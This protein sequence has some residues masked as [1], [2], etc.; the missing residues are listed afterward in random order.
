[1]SL[2]SILKNISYSFGGNLLSFLV[3]VIMVLFVPKFLPILDYS[4]WQL[5]LF[6]FS[7]V[8]FFHLGW[9]DGI[10]L[11]YAG[12]KYKELDR[13]LFAGQLYAILLLQIMIA[14]GMWLFA[15]YGVDDPVKSYVL[16]CTAVL[17]PFVNFNNACNQIMQFTNRI[18]EYAQLLVTGRLLLL[19]FVSFFLFLGWQTY[20]FMYYAQTFSVVG[21][22]IFGAYL[23]RQLLHIDFYSLSSVIHEAWI[24]I[25]VGSQL[26][27]ANIASMLIIGIVRYGISIGWDVT[28]FGKISLTLNISNFLMVFIGS[29]SI[30][31]FPLLKQVRQERLPSLYKEIRTLL[32]VSLLAMLI[33]YYPLKSLLSWWLPQYVDSLIYMVVLFPICLFESKMQLLINTYLKSMRQET[34]M[35]K[36][37][38]AAVMLS[39]VVTAV[40]V[41]YFHNLFIAVFSIVFLYA[42]RC[43]LAEFWVG[44]LLN[45]SL[46]RDMMEELVMVA[47]FIFS[48][49]VLDS[50][51]CM[52]VYGASYLIYFLAHGRDIKTLW[53]NI[54]QRMR[55]ESE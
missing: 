30:V 22:F 24:D 43:W 19:I 28:T 34:L 33:V 40:S 2:R 37:N 10:Y 14:V 35:L 44:Q 51:L 9:E 15:S 23:C 53:G 39:G 12:K 7:Y 55:N 4:M 17:I 47:I 36:I 32:S 5:F 6:Y 26:M 3:S 1:M 52:I 8:G 16:K 20:A 45:L 49:L 46:R 27:F 42:F 21:L 38:V 25:K 18:R 54:R 29:V 11:R 48:G 50:W 13:K 41:L 31:L